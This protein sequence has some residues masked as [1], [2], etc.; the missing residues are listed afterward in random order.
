MV[1][2]LKELTEALE[3]DTPEEVL[4]MI[5]REVERIKEAL[6]NGKV[7]EVAGVKISRAV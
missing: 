4:P 7:Y 2:D 3:K 1:T 6:D 5:L